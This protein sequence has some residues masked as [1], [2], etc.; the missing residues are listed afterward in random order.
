MKAYD[1]AG[2]RHYCH[3]ETA[4]VVN[5]RWFCNCLGEHYFASSSRAAQR[6]AAA[7]RV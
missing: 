2:R 4:T 3:D 7:V 1:S 5:D 6:M